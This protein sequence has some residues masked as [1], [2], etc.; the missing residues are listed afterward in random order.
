MTGTA[1]LLLGLFGLARLF[2]AS[3]CGAAEAVGTLV[4]GSGQVMAVTQGKTRG[5]LKP[6]D[7]VY[8]GDKLTSDTGASGKFLM[9]DRT[10]LDLNP[11]SQ[12][13]I[14]QFEP[15]NGADRSVEL[16]IVTGNV[17]VSVNTPVK[18]I[19]KFNIRTKTAAMGVRGTEFVVSSAAK[20]DQSQV[21]VLKGLV[22]VAPLSGGGAPVGVSP[23]KQLTM[24]SG[25]APR[26]ETLSALQL[27]AV[28]NSATVRNVTFNSNVE[29]KKSAAR[30][31]SSGSAAVL[32]AVNDS[33]S[34]SPASTS[35]SL[36]ASAASASIP[37]NLDSQQSLH[38]QLTPSL[39]GQPVK[40]SVRLTP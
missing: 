34:R 33:A 1:S 19:G 37:G 30:S 4:S 9:K 35:A 18:G 38:T 3:P 13:V 11:A 16:N 23:G 40:V 14:T 7:S 22:Q 15:H 8:Q 12:L 29:V 26:L 2:S 6:G 28:A 20:S 5:P 24:S 39:A 25:R 27:S 31:G 10:I 36:S 17:R 21:T 32:A